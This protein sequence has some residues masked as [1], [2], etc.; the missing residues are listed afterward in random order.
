MEYVPIK[1]LI[2]IANES[3]KNQE[4]DKNHLVKCWMVNTK[5]NVHFYLLT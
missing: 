1:N 2:F 4:E 5:Q 3:P